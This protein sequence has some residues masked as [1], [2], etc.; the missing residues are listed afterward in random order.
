MIP[1]Y[2]A[3][4]THDGNRTLQASTD[5]WRALVA[6]LRAEATAMPIRERGAYQ[7]L[8]SRIAAELGDR[9]DPA[10]RITLPDAEAVAILHAAGVSA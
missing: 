5:A 1:I 4:A 8:A 7:A 6:H 2:T 3:P 9:D 10:V